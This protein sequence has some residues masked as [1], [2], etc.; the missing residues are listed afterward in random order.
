MCH[1]AVYH[2]SFICPPSPLSTTTTTHRDW[3]TALPL[4]H[5]ICS[6]GGLHIPN[7]GARL[8]GWR[9]GRGRAFISKRISAFFGARSRWD[10]DAE[11]STRVG[12]QT[13]GVGGL[14]VVSWRR[15]RQSLFPS[16]FLSLSLQRRAASASASVR[17][18]L[19]GL[20]QHLPPS[21]VIPSPSHGMACH[22]M[23]WWSAHIINHQPPLPHL[24]SPHP[25]YI[26]ALI[27]SRN[28]QPGLTLFHP[29]QS[30]PAPAI[31]AHPCYARYARITPSPPSTHPILLLEYGFPHRTAREVV[32]AVTGLIAKQTPRQVIMGADVDR[33]HHPIQHHHQRQHHHQDLAAT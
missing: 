11:Y 17:R 32:N 3:S 10:V 4:P 25:Q 24:T 2:W 30:P 33:G 20:R 27:H 14:M 7:H 18:S 19:Y 1:L 29:T 6:R 8:D 26:S 9:Q 15:G 31:V 21:N 23:P 22:G 12:M 13:A 5:P 28:P 16:L